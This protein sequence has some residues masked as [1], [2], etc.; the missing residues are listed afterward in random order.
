[1]STNSYSTEPAHRLYQRLGFVR[2]PERDWSPL[3]GV[4]L[5]VYRLDLA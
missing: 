1:M 5:V 2:C 3:P 4:E